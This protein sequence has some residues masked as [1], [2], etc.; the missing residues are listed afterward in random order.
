MSNIIG[1][2]KQENNDKK[3]A[4]FDLSMW[5]CY[6]VKDAPKQNN[7]YDSGIFICKYAEYICRGKDQFNFEQ[8]IF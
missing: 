4:T 1:Y 5:N 8:V 3:S 7:A 2:L 6:H